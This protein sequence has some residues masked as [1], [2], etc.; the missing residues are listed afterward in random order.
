T[1][2]EALLRWQHPRRGL[3]PP[4]EFIPNAE[5]TGLI[6]EIGEWVIRRACATLSDW[7][8]DIR[9]AVNFS[10]AQFHSTGILQTIV[11]ALADAQRAP[12][13]LPRGR[14]P[15]MSRVRDI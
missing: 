1:G 14:A 9:V 10:A 7:P 15:L 5:E 13:R 4:S 12:H 3:V 6:H 11:Q 8:E 2:F